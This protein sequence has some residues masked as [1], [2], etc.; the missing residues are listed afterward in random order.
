MKNEIVYTI[1]FGC[2]ASM[3]AVAAMI[4]NFIQRRHKGEDTQLSHCEDKIFGLFLLRRLL[5]L[6]SRN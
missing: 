5:I 4:Q 2:I 6:V 3:L 1:I